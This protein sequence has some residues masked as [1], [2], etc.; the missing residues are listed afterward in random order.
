MRAARCLTSAS[1]RLLHSGPT[2]EAAGAA[3]AGRATSHAPTEGGRLPNREH[4]L[5]ALERSRASQRLGDGGVKLP[6]KSRRSVGASFEAVGKAA[7]AGDEKATLAALRDLPDEF[8]CHG[9]VHAVRI[10]LKSPAGD[11]GANAFFI[12]ALDG[13]L[14]LQT[15]GGAAAVL[16]QYRCNSAEG[17]GAAEEII[18]FALEL[19]Q[20]VELPPSSVARVLRIAGELGDGLLLRE[21]WSALSRAEPTLGECNSF[22]RAALV[23]GD[24]DATDL[25]LGTIA[26]VHGSVNGDTLVALFSAAST[27]EEASTGSRQSS[28]WPFPHL[29]MVALRRTSCISGPLIRTHH[30]P[31]ATRAGPCCLG[32]GLVVSQRRAAPDAPPLP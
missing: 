4:L 10:L 32:T 21:L 11:K 26:D 16:L 18:A 15:G 2:A 8:A 5:C 20:R 24:A 1:R 19:R 30:S 29:M 28:A 22:L 7:T 9:A 3:A 25:A 12:A 6:E 27:R 23:C 31:R 14:T 17:P 13:V